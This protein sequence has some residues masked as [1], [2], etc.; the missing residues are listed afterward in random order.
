MTDLKRLLRQRMLEDVIAPCRKRR[1]EMLVMVVDERTVKTVSSCLRMHELNAVGVGVA[2]DIQFERE[3]MDCGAVYLLTP[4]R[5]SVRRLCA[6]FDKKDKPKYRRAHVFFSCHLPDELFEMIRSHAYLPR[7]IASLK[8][9]Y[10]DFIAAEPRVFVCGHPMPWTPAA[11]YLPHVSQAAREADDSRM[12]VEALLDDSASR[13]AALCVALQE[14]AP[15]IRHCS[16]SSLNEALAQRVHARLSHAQKSLNLPVKEKRATL[17]ILDRTAMPLAALMHDFAY[18]AAI[19]DF[20]GFDGERVQN[21]LVNKNCE[22]VPRADDPARRQ[23]QAKNKE[24]REIMLKE[25]DEV[26]AATRDLHFFPAAREINARLQTFIETNAAV[27]LQRKEKRETRDLRDAIQALPQYYEQM[28]VF[29]LHSTLS[30]RIRDLVR[31]QEGPLASAAR[32]EQ[33]LATGFDEYSQFIPLSKAQ[34]QLSSQLMREDMHSALKLR[35]LL[36]Y[37]CAA[38]G[39]DT[40][41][42]ETLFSNIAL[43]AQQRQAVVNLRYLGCNIGDAAALRSSNGGEKKSGFLSKLR[44]LHTRRDLADRNP[45]YFS[46]MRVEAVQ[47]HIEQS[48]LTF[49]RFVPKVREYVESLVSV[50]VLALVELLCLDQG[51]AFRCENRLTK[52]MRPTRRSTF[53][54]RSRFF[55]FFS[56]LVFSPFISFLS[57]FFHSFHFL[58]FLPFI[59]SFHPSFHSFLH[60]FLSSSISFLHS[61]LNSSFHCLPCVN[62]F[63]SFLLYCAFR[64]DCSRAGPHGVSVP[65]ADT[66]GRLHAR[67][68]PASTG[69]ER[70]VGSPC[71]SARSQPTAGPGVQRR[72]RC[73]RRTAE[74]HR[75]CAGRLDLFGKARVARSCKAETGGSRSRQQRLHHAAAVRRRTWPRQTGHGAT[76]AENA[77]DYRACGLLDFAH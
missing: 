19:A 54:V 43:S 33:D 71:R 1:N 9:A 39:I 46:D 14:A 56:C 29:G 44:R 32:M 40:T 13:I 31:D 6:D 18:E 5:A 2:V 63:L 52:A 60:S 73:V 51:C 72:G 61:F 23:Q 15:H 28:R 30:A 37:V 75:L 50:L 70:Q 36:V 35:L 7:F 68:C 58:S 25:E 69:V 55:L 27:A 45:L 77:G 10:C 66:A 41:I 24:L 62:S 74:T 4:S 34:E 48:E 38:G 57:F 76:P 22:L 53:L 65:H 8:D 3:R 17:L 26:W 20:F 67:T 49:M 11:L 64:A 12:S 59:P 16:S 42:L 47:Q 21:F